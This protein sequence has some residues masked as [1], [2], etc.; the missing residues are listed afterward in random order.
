MVKMFQALSKSVKR[1]GVEIGVGHSPDGSF[2]DNSD[3]P[4]MLRNLILRALKWIVC[5]LGSL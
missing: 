5:E 2:V 1:I 4:L 3:H